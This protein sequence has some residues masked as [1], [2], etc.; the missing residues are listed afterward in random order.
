MDRRRFLELGA[1]AGA[2]LVLRPARL[3]AAD[4]P[5]H[6]LIRPPRSSEAEKIAKNRL[7]GNPSA[8]AIG[9]PTIA[10]R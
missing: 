3:L 6:G 1:V 10:G 9:A 7:T 4:G 5:T 8:V 2:G